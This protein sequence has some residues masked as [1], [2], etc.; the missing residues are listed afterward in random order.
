M[1]TQ[2]IDKIIMPS[3]ALSFSIFGLLALLLLYMIHGLHFDYKEALG[4]LG[5]FVAIAYIMPV[6]GGYLAD[7]YFERRSLIF[8]GSILMAIGFFTLAFSEDSLRF[9]YLGLSFI[10]VGH[11]FFVPNF[12]NYVGDI[13]NSVLKK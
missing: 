10:A 9:L 4:H 2:S 11:G 12:M 6:L 3:A 5:S 7:R 13:R 8:A 1:N